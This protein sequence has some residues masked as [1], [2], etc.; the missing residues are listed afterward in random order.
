VR[1]DHLTEAE[2][3]E[4]A[5]ILGVVQELLDLA[6]PIVARSPWT[7][8]VVRVQKAVQERLIN[9]LRETHDDMRYRLKQPEDRSGMY[10]AVGYRPG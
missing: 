9:P 3:A 1:L 10:P 5:R 7:D 2:H 4:L 6:V 8:K